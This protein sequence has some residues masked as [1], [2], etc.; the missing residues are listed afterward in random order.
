MPRNVNVRAIHMTSRYVVICICV[1]MQPSHSIEK[2]LQ[3]HQNE[4]H[5]SHQSLTNSE[6]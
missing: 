5:T 6:V 4:N 3:R 2:Q 1:N